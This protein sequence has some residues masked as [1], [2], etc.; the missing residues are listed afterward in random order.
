MSSVRLP[1][2]C[3]INQAYALPL[4]VMMESLKEHLR[5]DVRP[6]LY[7]MHA[8]LSD[9]TLAALGTIV[10]THPIVP[11]AAQLAAAP[12]DAHFPREAS[13][14]LLMPELLPESL[15]RVL[16]MDAD[17]LVL[18]DV[19]PLWDTPLEGHVLAAAVDGAV[20]RCSAPR[21]VKGW[22]ARGIPADAPYFNCGLLLA[23][24]GRWRQRDVTR[25]ALQYM[26][27]TREPIDFLHQEALNA[28]LWDDWQRLDQRWNLPASPAGPFAARGPELRRPGIV[29]FAGR[30]K[31]WRTPIGGPFH[32][33]YR[34]VL[35][36]VLTR[37]AVEPPTTRERVYGMYD[38]YGR[39]AFGPVERFLW[40]RRLL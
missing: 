24:L 5:Q 11:S 40:R 33:P 6:V 12:S 34:R 32:A 31:P 3:A 36:R 23:D 9:G 26:R 25:S 16:F 22:R 17:M 18:D 14:P 10:E 4:A 20:P 2:V 39:A 35:D 28:V 15:D 7:L 30:L 13:F 19:M 29:H 38:R 27:V 21:G 37:M 8:G 1:I